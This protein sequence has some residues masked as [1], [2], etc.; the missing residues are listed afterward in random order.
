M[1]KW[2]WP[3]EVVSAVA[4]AVAEAR[5]AAAIVSVWQ[6]ESAAVSEQLPDTAG[7]SVFLHSNPE[8]SSVLTVTT[9]RTAEPMWGLLLK[10]L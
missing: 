1:L 6:A 9:V 8:E 10:C 2:S 4:A 3:A 5:A 7:H